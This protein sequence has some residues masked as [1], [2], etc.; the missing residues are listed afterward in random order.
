MLPIN[1]FERDVK[2]RQS[3]SEGD[4]VPIDDTTVL[5]LRIEDEEDPLTSKEDDMCM[6]CKS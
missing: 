6:H 1:P 3:A 4:E 5:I 2:E